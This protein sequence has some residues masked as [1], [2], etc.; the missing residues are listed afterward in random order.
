MPLFLLL[1]FVSSVVGIFAWWRIFYRIGW[2][3]WYCLFMA[4]P[5]V[6]LAMLIVVALSKWPI[7]ERMT[8]METEL[9]RLHG[10]L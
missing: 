8:S 7:E 2:P 1:A 6:S 10:E 3:V 9:K 5:F 4:V